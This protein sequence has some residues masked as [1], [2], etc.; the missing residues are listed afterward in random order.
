MASESLFVKLNESVDGA[1]F[2]FLANNQAECGELTSYALKLTSHGVTLESL[3]TLSEEA[4]KELL[5]GE[6]VGMAPAHVERVLEGLARTEDAR[7]ILDP[8]PPRS[9]TLAN[10][11]FDTLDVDKSG[12]LDLGEYMAMVGHLPP[13]YRDAFPSS[14]LATDM[15]G[16][17]TVSRDEWLRLM[18]G[19]RY[20]ID[21]EYAFEQLLIQLQAYLKQLTIP[22]SKIDRTALIDKLF[23]AFDIDGNGEVELQEYMMMARSQGHAMELFGWF[24]YMDS[25]GKADGAIQISEFRAATA[26]FCKYLNDT[27][28]ASKMGAFTELVTT[29]RKQVA[30]LRAKQSALVFI[31]P[32]ANVPAV[33]ELVSET[34]ASVGI[35]VLAEGEIGGP[36]IDEK[37]FIDQHYY[38]IASKATILKPAE[39]PVP[40]DKFKAKFGE[41]WQDVVDGNGAHPM[42]NA[43]DAREHLGVSVAELDK[44]WKAATPVDK[45]V[46]LGGGFYCALLTE[47]LPEGKDPIYVFNA[48]FMSMR[49]KFTAPEAAITYFV[50]EFDPAVLAWGD[51]RGAVL[52]PTDPA[53]APGDS[54]RGMLNADW[55]SLGLAAAPNTTDNGVHAS[56]SPFEGLAERMNWL[57]ASIADDP[58]GKKLLAAGI[59]AETLT[60][61]SVDPRVPMP[62]GS[63]GSLF[64]ALED[65]DL[66]E[67]IE[68]A[69]AIAA[70]GV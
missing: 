46:K 26:M 18:L 16:S 53:K 28:F 42:F 9:F 31:K 19:Q 7:F 68:K 36:T 41:E 1:L 22:P 37:K 59:P 23:S 47:G 24:V 2:T 33:R 66:A 20:A 17:G 11:V 5:L 52:G 43:M 27:D 62:D 21:D 54:L 64:D 15:D 3:R 13:Q 4:V 69:V 56:A 57:Q 8:L 34:F 60:K 25:L 35:S 63:T 39:L 67:C 38:A 40:A 30:K 61:W 70:V 14:F 32:H 44:I 49:G 58:F 50:V 29:R 51:F 6:A 45:V 65:L 12:D 10:M 55:E 48:F